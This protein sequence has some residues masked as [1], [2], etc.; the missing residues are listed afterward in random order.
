MLIQYSNG[1]KKEVNDIDWSRKQN[2]RFSKIHGVASYLAM[3]CPALPE[4]FIN[5]YTEENDL[6]MD[7]FSGRG[8]TCLVSREKNRRF[9]G[10]DLNPYACVLTRFKSS[11]LSKNKVLKRIDNFEKEYENI[12]ENKNFN[13]NIEL[14]NFYSK[15]TLHQLCFLREKIGQKWNKLSMTDNAILA[16]ALGLMHG[17]MRKNGDTMYFSVSMPNAI[18]MSPNYV[19]KYV[20]EKKLKKPNINIFEKIKERLERIYD[21]IL[22]ENYDSKFW[23]FDATKDNKDIHNNSVKL[24]VTSP[25]YLNIVNYTNSNWLKLWLLGFERNELSKKIKLSDKLNFENY[26][27]FMKKYLNNIYPKLEEKA[28]VCL[29]VGDVHNN[30]LLENVWN[31]IK[32][33]VNFKWVKTYY[34]NNYKQEKKVTNMLN[35]KKGRA[36]I[37]EKVMVLEKK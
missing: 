9:V 35:K 27:L 16:I 19:K 31:E 24:V 10:T 7:N 4:Y 1:R 30:E 25:P 20:K 17:P 28:K 8:T 12:K 23:Y 5:K 21:Q 32:K 14:L 3:F 22:E 36:T 18:S 37:I 26:C 2:K 34:D 6:V 15:S 33:Q 29:V 13:Y 11:K